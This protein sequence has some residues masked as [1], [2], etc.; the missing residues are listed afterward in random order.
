MLV[1]VPMKCYTQPWYETISLP[2]QQHVA[3]I[4]VRTEGGGGGGGI[5][6]MC[7]PSFQAVPCPPYTSG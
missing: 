3:N 5:G 2:V 7:P 6:S 1:Y 4:S